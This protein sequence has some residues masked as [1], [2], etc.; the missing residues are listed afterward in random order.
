MLPFTPR[1]KD[2]L[3]GMMI[4]RSDGSNLG[5]L[6]FLELPKEQLYYGPM[7]IES[8]INQ[9]QTI[10][11][12]LTLWNQ[13]SSRV[14]RGQMTVLPVDNKFFFVQPL[15]LQADQARMPQLKKVVVAV[16]NRLIYTDTYDQALAE[17]GA[18][19]ASAKPAG[20]NETLTSEAKPTPPVS[21]TTMDPKA[22]LQSVRQKMDRYRQLASQGKWAEAGRELEAIDA[23]LRK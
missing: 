12:D 7:Q 20:S 2:N 22:K 1:G 18:A 17:L 5:E 13:Q 4:G 9:D 21:T 10:S 6:V 16:G 23:E 11:K 15:Y 19:A 3:I 8:R 14:V